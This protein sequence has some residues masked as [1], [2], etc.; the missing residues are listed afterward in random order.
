MENNVKEFV[1]LLYAGVEAWEKAGKMLVKM[2]STNPNIKDKILKDH[3]EISASVLVKLEK[4]GRGIIKP[5][6]L[7]SDAA[8]YRVVRSLP[9]SDQDRLLQDPQVPILIESSGTMDVIHVDFRYLSA[10][11]TK[12]VFAKDHIRTEAEQRAWMEDARKVEFKKEWEFVDGMVVFKK[13]ASL[14]I[15]QLSGI[16]QTAATSQSSVA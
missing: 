13:G 5:E 12:Q 2:M 10:T 11:Q 7:L 6:L 8:P 3:P 1:A 14:T 16:I 9:I 15:S 4:V